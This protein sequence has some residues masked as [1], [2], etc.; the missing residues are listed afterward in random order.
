[1]IGYAAVYG[2]P[3]TRPLSKR[4]CRILSA[5]WVNAMMSRPN[6]R[7]P[8][9]VGCLLANRSGEGSE[10]SAEVLS[11]HFFEVRDDSSLAVFD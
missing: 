10:T 4:I 1:V 9:F 5:S 8:D 3:W 7:R 6:V 11:P 2:A